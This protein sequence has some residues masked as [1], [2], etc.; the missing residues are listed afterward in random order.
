MLYIINK[1]LI[2]LLIL[3]ILVLL[4]APVTCN[5]VTYYRWCGEDTNQIE[6]N[7]IYIYNKYGK[8]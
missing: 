5:G 1:S 2:L 4:F 3:I 8:E 6:K 7:N